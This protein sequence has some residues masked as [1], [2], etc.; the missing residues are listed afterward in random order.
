MKRFAPVAILLLALGAAMAVSN[1]Q[2]IHAALFPLEGST[3]ES[4][5]ARTATDADGTTAS[6]TLPGV[7]DASTIEFE[8]DVTVAATAVDDTLDVFIQTTI[9]GTNW[10]DVVSFTQVLG[11]GGAKRYVAKI[12]KSEPQ[13]M[14][15]ASAALAAGSVRNILGKR[16]RARWAITD[17]GAD[18]ASFTFS[19]TANVLP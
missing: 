18:D 7:G 12:T 1:Y 15:E 3:L 10:I 6:G 2:T 13:A 11:N 14:F 9:D 19:I 4:S 16:Y 8:L 17:A 5:A